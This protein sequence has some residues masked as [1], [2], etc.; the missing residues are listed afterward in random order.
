MHSSANAL[1]DMLTASAIISTLMSMLS[2]AT[3]LPR[4]MGVQME[5]AVSTLMSV[6]V[7]L[8]QT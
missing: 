4:L 5:R 2:F 8:A 1:Q 3:S 7:A 6:R